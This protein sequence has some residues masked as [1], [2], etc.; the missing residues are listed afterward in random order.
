MIA[1]KFGVSIED[2]L[3]V[4]QEAVK[5]NAPNQ[6]F[7]LGAE[8]KIPGELDADDQRLQ[9]RDSK[10]TVIAKYQAAEAERQAK[11]G[12][13]IA[14]GDNGYYVTKDSSG[15]L[16][17]W[18]DEKKEISAEEFK[19]WCPTI[20][21]NV[22]EKND[23]YATDTEEEY[24]TNT[25]T[26]ESAEKLADQFYDIADHNAGLTSMKKMQNLLDNYIT[27][28]NI[29]AFLD[30]YDRD[31]TKHGDSSI[32]DTVISE[33]G[34]SGSTAQKKV[35]MT[36]LDKLCE[37]AKKAGVSQGDIDK[38]K[39]DFNDSY[40]YEYMQWNSYMRT[41]NPKDMEKAI[42][43]L[44]GAIA[45]KQTANV[46]DMSDSEAIAQFNES[47]G[48]EQNSAQGA[49]DD[50][51]G[52]GWSWSAKTGDWVC[53]LFG[54]NTISEMEAKLGK[55][56][57]A[58]K[59]LAEA[60]TEAEFKAKYKE[61]FG[62]EFDP[63]KIAAAEAA[64]TNLAMAQG[65]EKAIPI[66]DN[67]LNN[68]SNQSLAQ[69]ENSFKSQIG[70]KDEE[71]AQLKA[72]LYSSCSNDAEKKQAFI[73]YLQSAKQDLSEQYMNITKGKTLEQLEKD[74]ELVTKSA[75]GTNDIG[76][77]VAQFTTNMATTEMV[78][79]IAGD[80]ALTVALAAIPGGAAAGCARM[81]A[82]TARWGV[83]GVKVAKALNKVSKGFTAVQKFQSG[84]KYTSKAA[85][86]AAK[87]VSGSTAAAGG[88]AANSVLFTNRTKEEI[89]EMCLQNGIYGAIGAGAA[90]LAPKLMQV[91]PEFAKNS[92]LANEV[93]E[94]IISAVGAAGVTFAQGGEYGTTD[95][96][97]DIASG[98]L[99]ARLSHIG[100]G[101]AKTK[102]A[103][104]ANGAHHAES[105]GNAQNT[106]GAQGADN[107]QHTAKDAN[108]EG[109]MNTQ[110][111]DGAD[112]A[113]HTE[114]D[115]SANN[116]Q[117]SDGARHAK[118]AKAYAANQ[119][120]SASSI[121][122]YEVKTGRM[123]R[124][125]GYILN[126]DRLPVLELPNREYIDLNDP[127]ISKQ[128]LGLKE[129]QQITIGR[130]GDIPTNQN[131]D[132]VS[133][134]HLIIYK[135][136]GL[137]KLRDVSS[138]GTVVVKDASTAATSKLSLGKMTKNTPY[139]LEENNLPKVKL[140]DSMTI[141]LKDYKNRIEA[142]QEGQV[143]TIGREGDIK[144][145]GDLISGQH[146]VIYR[147]NGQ[148]KIKDISLNG[149]IIEKSSQNIFSRFEKH[150]KLTPQES[151]LLDKFRKNKT[152]AQA[153]AVN[154]SQAKKIAARL[155]E[156]MNDPSIVSP[157]LKNLIENGWVTGSSIEGNFRGSV[158]D[159]VMNDIA[160]LATE[161]DYIKKFEANTSMQSVFANTP[162]GEVA[163]V[164]GDLYVNN[165]SRM[166]KLNLSEETFRI[167][168][169][170]VKR[171]NTHQ[172]AIGTCYLVSSLERLYSSPL[173]RV[174]IYRLIGEDSGGIYT[175]TYNAKGNKNYFERWAS[176]DK[177][178]LDKDGL[179]VIEQ[180][181]CK[182]S[183]QEA[184]NFN[185]NETR[186]MELNDGGKSEWA[187]YGLLGETAIVERDQ[188]KMAEWIRKYANDDSIIMNCG[189]ISKHGQT[190]RDVLSQQYNIF[191]GHEYSI[192]GYD[193][194]TGCVIISNPW[195][196]GITTKIPMT[197]FLKYFSEI[198]Y[199]K[200]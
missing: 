52:E 50:A 186:I 79:E 12:E 136:N 73:S 178:I 103:D 165:G 172:G 131:N 159:N 64:Q 87:V 94:E 141:N 105:G 17:F 84:T 189:T 25:E 177:H 68:S 69:L 74:T 35:L 49:Y 190:D 65:F 57:Q 14:R 111:A 183:I 134:T 157:E 44:R 19:K 179:S 171:F 80:I 101:K 88:T 13:E 166:E 89:A 100:A 83:R 160:R 154:P 24:K 138:N 145:N 16:H 142:L 117:G 158:D 163:K 114:S 164:N 129:G 176:Q 81:A 169:P 133:R 56:A 167:L 48:A 162:V 15:N 59:E 181:Y 92:A 139:L 121:N 120:V 106:N 140:A 97:V 119:G 123:S 155:Q 168:F 99:M 2:L 147:S 174:Q 23:Y 143:L 5:G 76:K 128:L 54:C 148:L 102:T 197:E 118:N 193:Q 153:L 4:N 43:F 1:K 110:S 6:Y 40:N 60:K 161:G 61:V 46:E 194:S 18:N 41:T 107:A 7:L 196:S 173:G 37:A 98:V 182:G 135:E 151:A 125:T 170:P 95:A 187:I 71:F 30:A 184:M 150:T 149:T 70:I 78:T 112:G 29:C 67:L 10:E 130:D 85:N 188:I 93:A 55:N 192:K 185:P 127:E 9:N 45:A 26:R 146:L 109:T 115:G 137:L 75:F 91:F 113:H 126:N 104:N 21:K 32:I 198:S 191:A 33:I 96:V 175:K 122:P 116:A 180:G 108:T 11:T 66:Y 3:A 47:F 144:V 156:I 39:K 53:G 20:Y 51:K 124:D 132:G 72:N 200:L 63:Q 34:A 62:I 8:I 36:I 86:V 28:D 195:H 152:I 42:D 82:T 31:K 58:V 199:L 90:E 77:D 27:A 22:T 38:A